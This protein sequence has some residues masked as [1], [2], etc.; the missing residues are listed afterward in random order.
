MNP[1]FN[2][3]IT[4]IK[5]N[6]FDIPIYEGTF[7]YDNGF[8]KAFTHDGNIHKLYKYK[9]NDDLTLKVTKYKEYID[10][11][12]ETWLDTANRMKHDFYIGYNRLRKCEGYNTILTC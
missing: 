6:G 9:V 8:I 3:F 11:K 5:D 4:F 7:W 2:E 12:F 10:A 1:I